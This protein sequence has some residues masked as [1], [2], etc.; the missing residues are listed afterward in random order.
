MVGERGNHNDTRFQVF[1]QH[2][3][4]GIEIRV[5]CVSDVFD[6][7]LNQIN[8]GKSRIVKR[9]AVRGA[10]APGSDCVCADYAKIGEWLQKLS[11]NVG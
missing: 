10:M 5:S 6:R 4:V 9:S 7:I 11:Q 3:F 2:A 1:L 8:T